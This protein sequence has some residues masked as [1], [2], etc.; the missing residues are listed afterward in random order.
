M[1]KLVLVSLVS[2]VSV[3]SVKA[4][5]FIVD[6]ICYV[7]DGYSGKLE[8][9]TYTGS[10]KSHIQFSSAN[11]S[12]YLSIA[13]CK[14]LGLLLEKEYKRAKK[15]KNIADSLGTKELTKTMN[16]TLYTSGGMIYDY[17][18]ET[19]GPSLIEIRYERSER[20][21]AYGEIE[22]HSNFLVIECFQTKGVYSSLES[23]VGIDL[24][25]PTEEKELFNLIYCLKNIDQKVLA[26]KQNRSK[27]SSTFK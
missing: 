8:Y 10:N 24:N 3:V 18:F 17:G 26:I 23:Y 19:A 2:L 5:D 6:S 20:T 21:S 27:I 14:Q 15:W 11:N 25:N 13:T 22:G 12:I 16:K 1:K 7:G 9:E 4:Q